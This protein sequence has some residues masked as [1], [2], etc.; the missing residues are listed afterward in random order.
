[1]P[2]QFICPPLGISQKENDNVKQQQQQQQQQQQEQQQLMT[3][4]A[5]FRVD[6]TNDGGAEL[7]CPNEQFARGVSTPFG[8]FSGPCQTLRG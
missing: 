8:P 4:D 1:M 5:S 3:H 6:T 7:A 2:K